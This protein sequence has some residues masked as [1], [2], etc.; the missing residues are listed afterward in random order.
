MFNNN[1]YFP[2]YLFFFFSF[3]NPIRPITGPFMY[4]CLN[5]DLKIKKLCAIE[6]SLTEEDEETLIPTT[7]NYLYIKDSCGSK[8]QCK[9][10]DDSILYQCFPKL[11]KLKIGEKCSVNE[12]C[13]TGFCSMSICMGVDFEA[14]C[15]DYPNACKPGTYCTYSS[16]FNKK[17]CVEYAYMNEIC[18][19]S[20]TL[21]YTKECLPGLLCQIRDDNS[22][23]TVCKKWGS[24][25]LN[26][27]VTDERLCKSGMALYDTEI[28][29]KLKCISVDEEGECDEETHQ[30]NPFILGIG[31]NPDVPEELVLDCVGGLT[32]LYACPLSY[33]KSQ[34]FGKYIDEYNKKF[35]G[36]KL[37]KSQYFIDGYFNDKTMTE[38][39]IKYKQIEY[40]KAYE[41]IDFEGNINGLYSCEYEFFWRFLSSD[42]IKLDLMKIIFIIILLFQ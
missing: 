18:G 20:A 23:T 7:T 15:T 12:E 19:E 26:K 35:D 27:E 28:D 33:T 16:I 8:E 42:L 1:F 14:D 17:I 38:L 3:F 39:Y 11:K 13:Y 30:C 25:D 37:Q 6:G 24:F 22:G 32:N 9:Q 41:L 2:L 21:G 34:I 31:E 10:M 36:E 5:N 40:L 29:N 4:R